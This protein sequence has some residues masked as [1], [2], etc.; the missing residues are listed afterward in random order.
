M[1]HREGEEAE[2]LWRRTPGCPGQEW[3]TH[4]R[5]PLHFLA[6]QLAEGRG[7]TDTNARKEDT[8]RA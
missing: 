4:A 7:N 3:Y 6:W 1:R 5:P 8:S 2:W